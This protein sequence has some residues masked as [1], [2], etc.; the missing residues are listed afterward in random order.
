M[1]PQ[2][3]ANIVT[4][5]A[6]LSALGSNH[7]WFGPANAASVGFPF[8]VRVEV[9]KNGVAIASGDIPNVSA[10]GTAF[11]NAVDKAASLALAGA[12]DF[13]SGDQLSVR[14]SARVAEGV[15]LPLGKNSGTLRLWFDDAAAATGFSATVSGAAQTYY[16][17]SGSSLSGAA[18]AGPVATADVLAKATVNV[19][20]RKV[21]GGNPYQALGTWNLTY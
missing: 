3:A 10:T 9:L 4:R 6:G 19:L 15:T 5:Y 17:H 20:T 16:L 7:F 2:P 18:G 11:A 12:L 8:D 1:A 14:L 13:F 21:T